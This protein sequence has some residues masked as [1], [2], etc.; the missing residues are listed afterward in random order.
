MSQESVNTL[1]QACLA[2]PL[3]ED[4]AQL[5]TSK[6]AGDDNE[7]PCFIRASEFPS[8]KLQPFSQGYPPSQNPSKQATTLS[9]ITL[10]SSPQPFPPF[11]DITVGGN[12]AFNAGPG[13]DLAT[14]LGTPDGWN[15]AQDLEQ[16]IKGGGR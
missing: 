5:L 6:S 13:Y 8:T 16:Y 9:S 12:M 1:A 2:A 11:H 15:L 7:P 14:G 10:A 3:S 4:E